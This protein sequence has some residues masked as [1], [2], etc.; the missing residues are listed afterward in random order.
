[1]K[2]DADTRKLVESIDRLEDALAS[3]FTQ[4]EIPMEIQKAVADVEIA[5]SEAGL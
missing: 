3:Y 5:M 1:V 4:R 2:V